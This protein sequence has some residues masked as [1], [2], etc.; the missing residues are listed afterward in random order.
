MT[1]LAFRA[2]ETKMNRATKWILWVVAAI[3][4]MFGIL[5]AVESFASDVET[6]NFIYDGF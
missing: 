2:I 5:I 3:V 4:L 1:G 6:S